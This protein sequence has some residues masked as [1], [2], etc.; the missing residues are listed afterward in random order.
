MSEQKQAVL[1]ALRSRLR[2]SAPTPAPGPDPFPLAAR[3]ACD[4]ADPDDPF[5]AR[6]VETLTLPATSGT[7][8]LS[9]PAALGDAMRLLA[10]LTERPAFVRHVLLAAPHVAS[11]ALGSARVSTQASRAAAAG[12]FAA[13]LEFHARHARNR[14]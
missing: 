14:R 3:L 4:V 8:H 1:A 12:V 11:M 9:P 10:L 13:G 6:L 2:P 7:V 5:A